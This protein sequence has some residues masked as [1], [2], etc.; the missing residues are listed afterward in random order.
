[1]AEISGPLDVNNNVEV[2]TPLNKDHAGYLVLVGE[3]HD[4]ASGA[5]ILRRAIRVT[6]DG[7]LRVGIDQVEAQDTFNHAISDVSRYQMVTSVA[8]IAM[9]GGYL[10]LNAGNSTASGS[11]ARVQTYRPFLL[12]SGSSTEVA[13]RARLP[14]ALQANNVGELGLGYAATTA[15]PTDGVYFKI[16]STGELV[17]C[18]NLGGVE[19]T[20][21]AFPAPTPNENNYYRIIID[22]DRAEFYINGILRGSL[23]AGS[24]AGALT[25]SRALPLL[26]RLYNSAATTGAQRLEISDWSCITKDIARNRDWQTVQAGSEL[27][28][29]IAAPGAT[30]GQTA[31]YAN[32]AAPASAT[33]SNTAAGYT[34]LGGQFQFA[35]VAGAETDYALF[36]FQ[37]PAAAAAGGNKNL[38]VTGV[39]IETY[40]MGA[41]VG[42]SATVLQWG[43]GIG[44]TAV[45]LATADSATAGTR[46]PRRILL[47]VQSLAASAPI[48]A[49]ATPIDVKFPTPLFV[50]A[51]TFFHVILKMPAGLATASQIIRG[52]V[53][54]N[55]YWE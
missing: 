9:T 33:L 32:T 8:T 12:N 23:D 39:R 49:A 26:M 43:L 15:T 41:A 55:G 28:S 27:G 30:A 19:V 35:A 20:T 52:T 5:P 4:G 1:M 16:N 45:S 36:G 10:V 42:A 6:P 18:V 48:G 50:A 51:G 17:G 31:N 24:G 40:N 21:A 2:N 25:F 46:A 37:V 7:R 3:S 22:Q 54:V 53:L 11:V 13:F 34:T 29:Y 47:G 14:I 38:M 44:S